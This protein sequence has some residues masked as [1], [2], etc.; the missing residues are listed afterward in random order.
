MSKTLT[1][2][3][4]LSILAGLLMGAESWGAQ[5]G[6]VGRW[7]MDESS[8]GTAADATLLANHGS[9]QGSPVIATD[10]PGVPAAG[11]RHLE[12]SG[13]S[14]VRIYDVGSPI[15]QAPFATV[16]DTFTMAFW[17][18][19]TAARNS[20]SEATSGTGGTTGQRYAIFA[21]NGDAC[22]A[23]GHSGAGVSV[24]TNGIAV[25]EHAAYYMPALL[26][27]NAAIS[28]WVH[29]AVVYSGKRPSLYVNGALVR[30]GLLSTKTVHPSPGFSTD[31]SYGQYQGGL[32][33]VRLY[34]R[35]LT[36]SEVAALAAGAETGVPVV[37]PTPTPPAAGLA[38]AS[39]GIDHG[40]GDAPCGGSA[41][42]GAGVLL[43]ALLPLA[44][45]ISRNSANGS[46]PVQNE[47]LRS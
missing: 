40:A 41:A 37:T 36:T 8:G 17:A 24:G 21:A 7:R 29:V 39:D 14:H 2:P 46:R 13:G 35:A 10:G 38:A 25:V 31:S 42:G 20:L 33:D 3:V 30:E 4:V 15:P 47:G 23:A 32:D 12:F 22:W 45:M 44:E 28:G 16:T 1:G 9:H 11:L 27:H 18:R 34:D 19:P 5:S 26:V 6:L 43:I